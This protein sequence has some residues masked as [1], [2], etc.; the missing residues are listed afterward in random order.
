MQRLEDLNWN[1]QTLETEYSFLEKLMNEQKDDLE[2]A[3]SWS[4][5]PKSKTTLIKEWKW[6]PKAD[7]IINLKTSTLTDL[8]LVAAYVT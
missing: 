3:K 1:Y 8:T 2:K 5:H 4:K 6:Q 7:Y